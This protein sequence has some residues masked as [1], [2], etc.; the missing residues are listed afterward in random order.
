MISFPNAKI[1]IGLHVLAR[2]PDGFHEIETLMLPI[3]FT[4]ILE[5][6]PAES[7]GLRFSVSGIALGGAVGENLCEKAYGVMNSLFPLQGAYVHLHK[8]LPAGAGLGGGSADGAFLLR[9][10]NE[11][12][13]RGLSIDQLEL[14]ALQLGSDCPFFV[15]N[16][17]A[18]ATGRGEILDPFCPDLGRLQV[19]ILVPKFR[20]STAWAYQQLI[21]KPH[22]APLKGLLSRPVAEWRSN[23]TNDFEQAVFAH[24]PEAARMKEEL[25]KCGA[26]YAQ[27]SGSGSSFFGLFPSTPSLPSHLQKDCR[28]TGPALIEYPGVASGV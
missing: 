5:L 6:M 2:R 26:V 10:L 20:I 21:P 14:I 16:A 3:G 24:N 13:H 28:Y 4:D 19:A 25:Y 7:P 11:V 8:Q 15:N 27:M 23:I 12:F 18:I 17:P 1:N 22:R 9:M